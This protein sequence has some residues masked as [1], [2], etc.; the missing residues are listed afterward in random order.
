MELYYIVWERQ[1]DN[2]KIDRLMDRYIYIY[3]HIVFKMVVVLYKAR[4]FGV[5]EL[6][7]GPAMAQWRLEKGSL[8]ARGFWNPLFSS[9]IFGAYELASGPGRVKWR[10]VV[11]ALF[12]GAKWG[13]RFVNF[14]SVVR[15]G[16]RLFF[17]GCH[18]G[19][20]LLHLQNL[21]R[22]GTL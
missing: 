12:S 21:A 7:R 3:T 19:G 8:A 13:F 17:L 14:Q 9:S 15:S 20:F 18:S 6:T 2:T 1:R 11:S 4:I 22:C 16:P 10:P 5:Y